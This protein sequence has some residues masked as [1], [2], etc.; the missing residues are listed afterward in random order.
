LKRNRQYIEKKILERSSNYI[1]PTG[2]GKDSV[3]EDLSGKLVAKSEISLKKQNT[4]YVMCRVAATVII[5]ILSSVVYLYSDSNISTESAETCEVYL[6]DG[7]Y[8]FLQSNSKI[9]FNKKQWSSNRKIELKGEAFFSVKKGSA[10]TVQTEAGNVQ[11]LGTKFNVINRN[12]MF[13]V[14]C[15]S[16]KVSVSSIN[17]TELKILTKG[18]STCRLE[19]GEL[20]EPSFTNIERILSRQKGVFYFEQSDLTLVFKEFERQFNVKIKYIEKEKR[21]FT[22]YFSNKKLETALKMVCKPM[23]LDYDMNDELVV[24]SGLARPN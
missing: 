21:K 12:K 22:G 15:I 5:L 23:E 11:V 9:S 18:M 19:S 3:W 13:E 1:V 6:P 2:K 14:A 10:F 8:V 16:G 24:V 7:S 4:S 17:E 20:S